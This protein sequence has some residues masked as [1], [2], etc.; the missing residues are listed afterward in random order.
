LFNPSP[1][2]TVHDLIAKIFVHCPHPETLLFFSGK[3]V[4]VARD[5]GH[6]GGHGGLPG[7]STLGITIT[8]LDGVVIDDV[9]LLVAVG[10]LR[11][12]IAGT[13]IVAVLVSILSFTLNLSSVHLN[14]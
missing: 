3:S 8:K 10:E 9:L 7:G 12:I 11:G 4:G 14:G 1:L 13:C 6:V 2:K 5:V